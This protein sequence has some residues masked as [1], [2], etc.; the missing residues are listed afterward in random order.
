VGAPTSAHFEK[1][2]SREG[3]PYGVAWRGKDYERVARL[4]DYRPDQIGCAGVEGRNAN[5]RANRRRQSLRGRNA[6]CEERDREDGCGA[7]HFTTIPFESM[8]DANLVPVR[9]EAVKAR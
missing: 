6:L 4:S 3:N 5:P 9:Q 7:E 2:E 8:C 1:I